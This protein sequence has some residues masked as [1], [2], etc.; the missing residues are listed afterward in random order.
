MRKHNARHLLATLAALAISPSSQS[1]VMELHPAPPFQYLADQDAPSIRRKSLFNHS[2]M[3]QR[4][5]RKFNRQRNAAGVKK[6]FA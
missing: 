1:N 5:R 3:N 4:Q 6:A 2:S